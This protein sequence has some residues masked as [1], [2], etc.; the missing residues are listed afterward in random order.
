MLDSIATFPTLNQ[1]VLDSTSKEMSISLKSSLYAD[2]VYLMQ[3]FTT[4][5]QSIGEKV[6]HTK[7]KIWN[8]LPPL[9]I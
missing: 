1:P 6:D 7:T 4:E 5:V 9:M 3:R 2:I 8:L